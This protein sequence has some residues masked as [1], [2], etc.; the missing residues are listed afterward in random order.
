[1][2]TSFL[3]LA[4]APISVFAQ[5]CLPDGIT[6]ADQASID[7]FA[8][9]H[10]GCTTIVGEVTITGNGI[11]DLDG[12]STI[13]AM[14]AGLSLLNCG[15]LADITGLDAMTSVGYLNINNCDQLVD[16]SGLGSI[17][18]IDGFLLVQNNA[19]LEDLNGLGAVSSV[20]DFVAIRSNAALQDMSGL[21]ALQSIGGYLQISEN[22]TLATLSGLGALGQVGEYMSVTS[23][24][25][26]ADI[27]NLGTLADVGTFVQVSNL[28]QLTSLDGL[29]QIDPAPLSSYSAFGCPQ[30]SAC[31]VAS[32]C[33]FIDLGGSPT[34]N[35]NASGC[36]NIPEVTA[37]CATVTI[38]EVASQPFAVEIDPTTGWVSVHSTRPGYIKVFDATG[39]QLLQ[40]RLTG[41]TTR[42]DPHHLN[43]AISIILVSQLDGRVIGTRRVSLMR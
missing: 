24:T 43:N 31:A 12:L 6:F 29:Q 34:I 41:Q 25:L 40:Q 5:D 36:A 2:R 16:L 15:A 18:T 28:P 22:P 39:R 23:C 26:L 10:P 30:L 35:G 8:T 3:F 19:V 38:D 1:M 21:D 27:S 17:T 32:L 42:I 37:A 20:E 7:G 14:P 9:A 11:T 4:L 13:T 33:G